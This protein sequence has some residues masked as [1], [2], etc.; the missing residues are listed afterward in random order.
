MATRTATTTAVPQGGGQ[1]VSWTGMQASGNDEGSAFYIPDA[2]TITVGAVI[3]TGGTGA[4]NMQGSF[5]GGSTAAD[6]H[7]MVNPAGGALAALT[8]SATGASP[9]IQVGSRPLY[10]RPVL[11]GSGNAADITVYMHIR[12]RG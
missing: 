2:G 6:W 7:T 9:L 8:I 11:S 10:I 4:L 5:T 1:L 12:P 3:G